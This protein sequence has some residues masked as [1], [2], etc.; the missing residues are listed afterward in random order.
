MPHIALPEGVPGIVSGF[1]FRP[2]TA[3]PMRSLAHT[4][5]F[6]PGAGAS[7]P[8][9]DREL[10][11]AYVSS[12]NQCYF[13]HASHAAAASHHVGGSDKSTEQVCADPETAPIPERLKAL[14]AIAGQVQSNAHSV[15]CAMIDRARQAGTKDPHIHDTV[16]I[17]AAF[18]M[19]NRYVDGL[20]TWQPRGEPMYD[21]MG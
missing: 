10:I 4:L 11:T 1:A 13:C 12:R 18:C 9:R 21:S 15:S 16:L 8:S 2:E 5:L 20:N 6:E 14:L 7:L 17:E 19:C 3:A